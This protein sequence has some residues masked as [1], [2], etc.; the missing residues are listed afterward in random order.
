MLTIGRGE[1]HLMKATPTFYVHNAE[2]VRS[3]PKDDDDMRPPGRS[4][5]KSKDDDVD[6][7]EADESLGSSHQEV[8]H[9]FRKSKT[10]QP[11]EKAEEGGGEEEEEE[12]RRC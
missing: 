2:E 6:M 5:G 12:D 11:E 8:L 10:A 7:T 9:A 3:E 4:C 1:L